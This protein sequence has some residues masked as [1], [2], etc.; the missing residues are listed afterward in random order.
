[1]KGIFVDTWTLNSWHSVRIVWWFH[2]MKTSVTVRGNLQH[3]D[4]RILGRWAFAVA[5]MIF[6]AHAYTRLLISAS[7]Y[8][9]VSFGSCLCWSVAHISHHIFRWQGEGNAVSDA[10]SSIKR[11]SPQQRANCG[12]GG[13]RLWLNWGQSG[14]CHPPQQ[15]LCCP[16]SRL[17]HPVLDARARTGYICCNNSSSSACS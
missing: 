16:R 9:F 11:N 3:F 10:Q 15:L 4:W 17:S 12:P 8:I 5:W 14:L 13:M 1:M 2:W 7:E 6:T